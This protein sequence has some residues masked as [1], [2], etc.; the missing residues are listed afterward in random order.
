MKQLSALLTLLIAAASLCSC[1]I[2]LTNEKTIAS[3]DGSA[4]KSKTRLYAQAGSRG[5]MTES[6]AGDYAVGADS[7]KSF[8]DG[9]IAAGTLGYIAGNVSIKKAE[10]ADAAAASLAKTVAGTEQARIS[11]TE[12]AVTTLGSNP[13]ANT[14]A[15]KAAGDAFR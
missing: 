2:G 13:E 11:S 7:E 15:I 4:T 9:M 14:G 8:R 1:A 6:A 3:A 10:S 12:R 5:G